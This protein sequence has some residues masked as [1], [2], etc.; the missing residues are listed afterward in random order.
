MNGY[1]VLSSIALFLWACV[2]TTEVRAQRDTPIPK[3]IHVLVPAYGNPCCDG[4][5]ELWA[6]LI[7]SAQDTSRNFEVVAILNPA[8]G[9]GD[10]RDL[11]YLD[12]DGK[13]GVIPRFRS[14]G[15]KLYGYVSTRYGNRNDDQ[16][17][18]DVDGYLKD[19][20]RYAGHVDGIFFDELSNDLANVARYRKWAQ[21]VK[22]NQPDAVAM[23][24]PGVAETLNPSGQT[25]YSANDYANVFDCMMT[26]EHSGKQYVERFTS[27]LS[28][29]Q[30]SSLRRSHAIHSQGNWEPSWLALAASRHADY[31]FVSDDFMR[32]SEDN[33]YD[34]IPKYWRSMLED[35]R[36]YNMKA[37][38]R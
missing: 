28:I 38:G 12:P 13:T 18:R 27:T 36:Q 5:P 10:Q 2:A 7:S 6:E 19:S 23:A 17:L 25:R 37:R 26:F 15:G 31:L 1:H 16:I 33:P 11:N 9:P 22:Q 20:H 21:Y 34:R 32:D 3:A 4:G 35:L 8:S 30:A 29:D 14:A 24:N